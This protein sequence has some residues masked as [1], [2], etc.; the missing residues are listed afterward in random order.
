VTPKPEAPR[1]ERDEAQSPAPQTDE[2]KRN[3]PP[4]ANGRRDED[5]PPPLSSGDPLTTPREQRP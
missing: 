5:V 2:P 1:T 3:D 4:S